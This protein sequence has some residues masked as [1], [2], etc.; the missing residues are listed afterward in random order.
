MSHNI[1]SCK[2]IKSELEYLSVR[3]A[4][5]WLDWAQKV[6]VNALTSCWW[7]VISGG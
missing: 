3:K 6:L 2:V 7:P 1:F 5:K 4:H